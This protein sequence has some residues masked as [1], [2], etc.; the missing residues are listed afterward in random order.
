MIE[1]RVRDYRG[2]ERADIEVAHIALVGGRNGSG[3]TSLAQ[4]IGSVL[5]GDALP[6]AGINRNSAGV[7]IRAGRD[8]AAAIVQSETGTAQVD[9]PSCTRR[10]ENEPP[11]ASAYAVG[12]KSIVAVP[13]RDRMV[14]LSEYLHAAPTRDDLAQAIA[15]ELE[16]SRPDIVEAVWDLIQSRG[17]WDAA[18]AVRRERG[19]ELKGQWRQITGQNYGSRIA[20]MFRPDLADEPRST[21]EL[22]A[23]VETARQSFEEAVATAAVSGEAKKR[24]EEMAANAGNL[25]MALRKA[26][27]IADG[28]EQALQQALDARAQCLPAVVGGGEIPCPHCG[29]MVL[30]MRRNL[31]ETVL[32]AAPTDRIDEGELKKRRLAIAG[33]DGDIARCRGELGNAQRQ[34]ADANHELQAALTA[35]VTLDTMPA[36]A[37]RGA[38]LERARAALAGAEK[39]LTEVRT[40][41]AADKVH[42]SVADNEVLL[43]IL[44][45]EGLRARKLIRVLDAFNQGPILRLTYAAGWGEVTLNPDL[46]VLYRGRHYALLSASEQFRVRVVLQLAMAQLDGSA[47]VVIDGAD[48]L[49]APG[50]QELFA[51][52]SDAGLPA[53][54]TMT[55]PIR[56]RM[57]DLT[58]AGLGNSYWLAAGLIEPITATSEAA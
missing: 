52:L 30:V 5:C 43:G 56:D 58:A 10:T 12:F 31:V 11:E 38:D 53:I 34:R 54:V 51:M 8:A 13:D 49:D 22:V 7:L 25:E 29:G 26:E 23:E 28:A 14:I 35:R 33:A 36:A 40:K 20:S 24:L 19:A 45:P 1:A 46:E 32:E 44:A 15:D 16:A 57:P 6:L 2:V 3:K 55:L 21:N 50:R 42:A 48:I 17:G 9:W 37:Q 47:M 39:R 41:R 4:A 27:A 18:C